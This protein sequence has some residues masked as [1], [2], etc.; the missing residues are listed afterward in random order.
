MKNPIIYEELKSPVTAQLE[1]TYK[2]TSRCNYCYNSWRGR[3]NLPKTSLSKEDSMTISKKLVEGELFEVVLTGGEPLL[4]RDIVYPCAK[5]LSQNNVDVG[6]NTNLILLNEDDIHKIRDSGISRVFASLPS[7]D[8]KLYNE[9]TK[10]K[11]FKK[12]VRGIETIIKNKLPLGINMVVT[13]T[14]K[15][16]VYEVG[17]LLYEK[18]VK[19]F[20]ATP[21]SPCSF[22]PRELELEKEEVV[23]TLDSLLMVEKDFNM[24][25]DVVEPLPRCITKNSKEYEQFFKRDCAAGKL[26]I[27]IS[28]G[29]KVRPCTHISKEYG[30]LLNEELSEIWDRMKSWREG[31]YIPKECHKCEEM[32]ICS[33]GCR[34]AAKIETGSYSKMEPWATEPLKENRKEI[35]VVSIPQ[36]KELKVIPNLRFRKEK[37]GYFVFSPR[38]H[39]AI[40]A[41]EEL[42]KVLSSLYN[43]GKFTLGELNKEEKRLGLVNIIKYLNVKGIVE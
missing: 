39:S 25:V 7:S 40:Y 27:A 17:K 4:R 33:F 8:E 20:S 36:D 30:N 3:K 35:K 43:R 6:L 11:S 37:R 9:I 22:M 19:Y 21:A 5:Y 31:K 1:T 38:D 28:P 12:A 15:H 10:T 13:K 14:N 2:C 42:F 26:T 41:N 23:H 18:G 16:Q 34:E 32:S 29:G 24:I